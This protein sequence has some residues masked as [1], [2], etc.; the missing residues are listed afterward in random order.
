ML[1]LKES[2]QCMLLFGLIKM[3][4]IHGILNILEI[5]KDYKNNQLLAD[6]L[7]QT[8]DMAVASRKRLFHLINSKTVSCGFNQ[9]TSDL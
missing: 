9:H 1:L 7:S 5:T 6:N 4:Y 2:T 8:E 3:V